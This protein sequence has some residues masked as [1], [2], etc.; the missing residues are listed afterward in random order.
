MQVPIEQQADHLVGDLQAADKHSA[1]GVQDAVL[2]ANLF[3]AQNPLLDQ[4]VD[5]VLEH[6]V[7]PIQ[8]FVDPVLEPA[9]L[10]S[11]PVVESSPVD[12]VPESQEGLVVLSE[13]ALAVA[14]ATVPRGSPPPL[15]PLAVVLPSLVS[16][17]VLTLLIMPNIPSLIQ[18][19]FYRD[20]NL[21]DSDPDILIPPYIVDIG[22]LSHLASILFVQDDAPSVF[23]PQLPDG[24]LPL[25][26]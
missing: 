4:L 2:A 8:F 22:L 24:G 25:V 5:P 17:K 18:H 13:A 6:V 3:D 15:T 21:L 16:V 12:V 20:L 9:Q 10:S 11:N 23:S 1:D 14:P 26:S 7:E 19:F